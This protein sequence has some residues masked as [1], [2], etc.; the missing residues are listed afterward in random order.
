MTAGRMPAGAPASDE[1][2]PCAASRA[3]IATRCRRAQNVGS[4]CLYRTCARLCGCPASKSSALVAAIAPNLDS[5]RY[6][7]RTRASRVAS[8]R[9]RPTVGLLLDLLCE[10][11]DEQVW[12]RVCSSIPSGR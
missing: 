6:E 10:S 11:P 3:Q 9:T 5:R 8:G 2:H 12:R 4:S 1:A 7:A